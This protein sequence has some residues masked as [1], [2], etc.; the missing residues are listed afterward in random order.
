MPEFKQIV[1]MLLAARKKT[2]RDF[3]SDF[4]PS[5]SAAQTTDYR[6]ID[7]PIEEKKSNVFSDEPT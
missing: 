2:F 1:M 5:K 4:H 6:V 7:I 3:S